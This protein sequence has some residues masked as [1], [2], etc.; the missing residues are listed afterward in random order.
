MPFEIPALTPTLKIACFPY[1]RKL[2][3]H[4]IAKI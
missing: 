1:R 4:K 2:S 3:L